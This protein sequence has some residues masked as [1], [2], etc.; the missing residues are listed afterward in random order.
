MI[1]NMRKRLKKL[2]LML[3]Q[4]VTKNL[5]LPNFIILIFVVVPIL[6]DKSPDCHNKR[7][8]FLVTGWCNEEFQNLAQKIEIE[9]REEKMKKM[10]A[11]P[12]KMS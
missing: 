7:L 9:F 1:E 2:G 3:N 4:S 11:Q 6:K 12:N 5:V 8:W 10:H